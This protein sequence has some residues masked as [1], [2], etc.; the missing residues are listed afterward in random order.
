[1]QPG[2][3]AAGCDVKCFNL[4]LPALF[5][6]LTHSF[7]VFAAVVLVQV[8]SLDVGGG[9]SIGIVEETITSVRHIFVREGYVPTNS[10]LNA[11]QDSGHIIRGTPAVL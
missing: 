2:G 6:G 7:D 8:R 9:R 11:G 1:M 10:P 4:I 5:H 3:R